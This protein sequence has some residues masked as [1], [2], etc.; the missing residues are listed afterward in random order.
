MKKTILRFGGFSALFMTL[1]FIADDFLL[2]D[3]LGYSA[4]EV[5]GWVGILISTLFIW[6]GVKYYR[7]RYNNGVISFGE[8][9]KLGLLILLFPSICFGVFNV[10]YVMMNPDFMDSYYQFKLGE[11]DSSLPAAE[12]Q[13]LRQKVAEEKEFFSN[14]G[15]QF[16]VMFVSVF[17][18][19]LIVTVISALTL[20]RSSAKAQETEFLSTQ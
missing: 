4:R 8:A 7:D 14:P 13:V 6:F 2:G 1:F 3:V 5:I 20:R 11:I 12:Q 18:I 16:L 19:G 9:M 10:I 17:A 15:I